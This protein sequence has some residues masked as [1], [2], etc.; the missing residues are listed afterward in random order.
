MTANAR[1]R[2]ETTLPR[3]PKRLL[4]EHIGLALLVWAG[5]AT[6]VLL[7][8]LG[9]AAVR[10]IEI[11]GWDQAA[12]AV[13]WYALFIGVHIG[14]SVLPLHVTHG[15]TRREFL[16]Q[17]AMFVPIFAA[18][19]SLL[20]TVTFAGETA[21]YRL[22]GW[23]QDVDARQLFGSAR[24]LHLIFLQSWLVTAMWTAGGV[25]LGVAWYRSDGLGS[26]AIGLSVLLAG[27]SGITV[28]SDWG[29]FGS[30]YEWFT[31]DQEVS[32]S[33]AVGNHLALLALL[34]GLTW[35]AVRDVPIRNKAA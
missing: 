28:G 25:F 4:E 27:I 29:P 31:G 21:L 32:R 15:Q 24:E 34:L 14:W 6:F 12:E 10:E 3:F 20:V 19:V 30:V 23:S 17:A 8:I 16:A 18:V 35:L 13:R 26:L 33:V 5:Y 1:T 11:S 9:V 22:A 2:R 7:L